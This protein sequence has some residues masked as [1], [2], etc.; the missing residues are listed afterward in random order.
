MSN[1]TIKTRRPFS[2][3]DVLVTVAVVA[4]AAALFGPQ[5]TNASDNRREAVLADQLRYIRTQIMVY[6]AHHGGVAPGYPGGDVTKTPDAQTFIAQ[7]C[8]NTDARGNTS[9]TYNKSYPY[10]PYLQQ[11]PANPYTDSTRIEIIHADQPF[12]RVPRGTGNWLYKPATC[13]FAADLDG[14]DASGVPLFEY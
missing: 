9:D 13:T 2:S 6:R 7:M 8:S 3:I 1:D 5:F 14:R 12:P 4:A 11:M 10:G